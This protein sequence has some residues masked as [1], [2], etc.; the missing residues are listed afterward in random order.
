MPITPAD[1][2]ANVKL[3]YGEGVSEREIARRLQMPKTTVH[4][5]IQLLKATGSTSRRISVGP[6]R[7][8]SARTD[9]M[10]RRAAVTNPTATSKDILA[11]LPDDVQCSTSTVRRRLIA[12]GLRA[13]RPAAKPRLSVKN[14]VRH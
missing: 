13:Y 6:R 5:I 3:L 2:R 11:A 1:K 14:I 7:C 9:K 8:T 10:M 12:A 4:D